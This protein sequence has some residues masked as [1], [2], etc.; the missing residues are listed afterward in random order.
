MEESLGGF[1]VVDLFSRVLP[2]FSVLLGESGIDSLS[3]CNELAER[4]DASKVSVQV[5]LRSLQ[6]A[7]Q[8]SRK[9]VL[10]YVLQSEGLFIKLFGVDFELWLSMA[11]GFKLGPDL[12][13]LFKI[14]LV[15]TLAEHAPL[16]VHLCDP[17]V[18]GSLLL[19]LKLRKRLLSFDSFGL[20]LLD[21]IHHLLLGKHASEG[22]R[23]WFL[24]ASEDVAAGVNHVLLLS[25]K[26]LEQISCFIVEVI[27][28][29]VLLLLGFLIQ[30]FWL[31]LWRNHVL[32]KYLLIHGSLYLFSVAID[33]DDIK[34][35]FVPFLGIFLLFELKQSPLEPSTGFGLR[36]ES[37]QV[38]VVSVMMVAS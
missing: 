14:G 19:G 6:L 36:L 23:G 35:V 34:H 11:V 18:E 30:L 2:V 28:W 29:I 26:L 20:Q 37:Y 8:V 24:T 33:I 5:V 31:L 4:L 10:G 32:I 16:M 27:L 21:L 7:Q 3:L 38:V 1:E 25:V 15:E 17:V 12:Q 13:S 9:V 22:G